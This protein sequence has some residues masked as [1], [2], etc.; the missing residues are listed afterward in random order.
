MVTTE[1]NTK[2]FLSHQD[3][4]LFFLFFLSYYPPFFFYLLLGLLNGWVV[5]FS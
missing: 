4:Y 2:D 5:G 3:Y 1:R